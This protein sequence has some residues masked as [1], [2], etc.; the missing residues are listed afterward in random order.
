VRARVRNFPP[1]LYKNTKQTTKACA[2][3]ARH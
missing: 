1:F 3:S 2:P